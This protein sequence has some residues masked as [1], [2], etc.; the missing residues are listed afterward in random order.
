[1]TT[2]NAASVISTGSGGVVFEQHVGASF[3]SALLVEGFLPIFIAAK[4]A[5][6]HFQARRLGWRTDD[7]VIEAND[8]TG[9]LHCLVC[10]CKRTFSVSALD[11]D[12]RQTFIAAWTDFH[13]R[14]LFDPAHDAVVLVVHLGTNR[15]LGDLG[16]LLAQVRASSSA[17]DFNQ[18]RLD[19]GLLNSRSGR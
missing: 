15:I 3:L 7:L 1:M 5:T 10:Q 17:D 16:W 12:C 13:N 14:A 2:A 18:R 11:D 4:P 8:P 6:V 19:S 9:Q